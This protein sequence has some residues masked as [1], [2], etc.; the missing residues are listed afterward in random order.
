MFQPG[1]PVVLIDGDFT[2]LRC[3][4]PPALVTPEEGQTYHVRDIMYTPGRGTG[5][6]L[7][8]LNNQHIAPERPECNFAIA[9]FRLLAELPALELSEIE[10]SHL[11]A[12]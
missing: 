6:T 9:R 3:Q 1:T 11:E 2:V 4:C 7:E 8:E 10:F 5:I 12:V